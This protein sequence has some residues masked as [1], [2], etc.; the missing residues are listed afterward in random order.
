MNILE[1]KGLY[2]DFRGLQVLFKLNLQVEEGD[3]HA[4]IGH[5]GAE[6][7]P[8]QPHHRDLQTG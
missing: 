4:V 5:N 3:R 8:L 1:T 6:D 2:H 7:T